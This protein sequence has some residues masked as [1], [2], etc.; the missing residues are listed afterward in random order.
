MFPFAANGAAVVRLTILPKISAYGTLSSSEI[1]FIN[2]LAS[3]LSICQAAKTL[4]E[5]F[6]PDSSNRRT[7]FSLFFSYRVRETN[8]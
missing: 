4:F 7:S 8:F 3:L 1:Q 5:L 2:K 6:R